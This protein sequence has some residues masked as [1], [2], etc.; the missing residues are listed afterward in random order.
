MIIGS[1]LVVL[2]MNKALGLSTGDTQGFENLIRRYIGSGNV[3]GEK[4]Q[5]VG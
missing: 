2:T 4:L 1:F 3:K 5:M